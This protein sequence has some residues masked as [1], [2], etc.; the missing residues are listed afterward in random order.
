MSN[1]ISIDEYLKFLKKYKNIPIVSIAIE[2]PNIPSIVVDSSIG[3]KK[4]I[5]HLIRDHKYKRLA[6]IQ[7][8][9]KHPEAFERFEVY[10]SVLKENNINYDPDLVVPGDFIEISGIKAIEILLDERKVDFDAIVSSNDDMAFGALKALQRRD[11]SIPNDIALV[12]FD[13]IQRSA[14][15][16]PPMTTVKQPL[17]EQGKKSLELLIDLIDRKED[18]PHLTILPTKAIYRRSCGCFSDQFSNISTEKNIRTGLDPFTQLNKEKKSIITKLHNIAVNHKTNLNYLHFKRIFDSYIEG[19]KNDDPLVF[20]KTN[21]EILRKEIT[22][23]HKLSYWHNLII[24]LYSLTIHFFNLDKEKKLFVENIIH[25]S[26]FQLEQLLFQRESIRREED[27]EKILILNSIRRSLMSNFTIQTLAKSIN[28]Q[29]PKIGV[30]SCYLCLFEDYKKITPYSILISAY[31]ESESTKY[32][33]TDNKERF[34]TAKLLPEKYLNK[35]RQY[36]LIVITVFFR[37]ENKFGYIVFESPE[38]VSEIQTLTRNIGIAL[39]GGLLLQERQLLLEKLASSNKELDEFASIVA[40]DLKQPLTV[41]QASLNILKET[42]SK[43]LDSESNE[44]IDFS[45][46]ASNRM[47]TMIDDLLHFSRVTTSMIEFNEIGL[48]S[49][50]DQVKSD[51]SVLIKDTKAEITNDP[52]PKIIGS[53]TLLTQLFQNLV[54]NAIKFRGERTPHIH[55]GVSDKNKSWIFTIKDNGI[56]IDKIYFEKIFQIFQRVNTNKKY[57]GTGIGLA[58][59]KKIVEKH[60]GSIWVESE[61]EKGSTFFFKIP[62]DLNSL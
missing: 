12:G 46:D 58:I 41:I 39:K 4:I 9:S 11:I 56:G 50:L 43:K 49:I 59:C 52:L 18:V 32:S 25:Q 10:K 5:N 22:K 28:E 54:N 36:N 13:D 34:K 31:N 33:I 26:R 60:K 44:L 1:F 15:C 47:K 20:L 35:N 19:I 17:Y 61:S 42:N 3:F 23:N 24:K 8:P 7:G 27:K 30:K 40:H 38:D 45:V 55:I 14:L 21:E 16:N 48:E 62:K 53:K 51:L 37:D 29:L 2:I 6:F 57:I